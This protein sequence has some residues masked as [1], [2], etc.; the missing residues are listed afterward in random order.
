MRSFPAAGLFYG[1]T[2][3]HHPGNFKSAVI[4][5]LTKGTSLDD[6]LRPDV[7]RPVIR[8]GSFNH[9]LYGEVEPEILSNAFTCATVVSTNGH[10]AWHSFI[11]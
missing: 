3:T 8:G 4:G 7:A 2:S 9:D 11:N 6:D 1:A 10:G 5:V